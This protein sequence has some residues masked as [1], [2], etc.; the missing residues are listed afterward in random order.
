MDSYETSSH[1]RVTVLCPQTSGPLMLSIF[2]V[3]V[4]FPFLDMD[5]FVG[6]VCILNWK[7][8]ACMEI[9]G[10]GHLHLFGS[11]LAA[12]SNWK[13]ISRA[14]ILI[15]QAI[16]TSKNITVGVD[17]VRFNLQNIF[18]SHKM[19]GSHQGRRDISLISLL[20]PTHF[21]LQHGQ[22][23]FPDFYEVS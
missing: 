4:F 7:I 1:S 20:Q 22:G 10:P 9:N 11:T 21:P 5:G 18:S 2:R 23:D 6:V 8:K 17:M 19:T 15:N 13:D 16:G 14:D 12:Y 3:E